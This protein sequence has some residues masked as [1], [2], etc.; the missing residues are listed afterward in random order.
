MLG[1]SAL[2]ALHLVRRPPAAGSAVPLG[3]GAGAAFASTLLSARVLRASAPA[4][5][6]LLPYCIYRVA[7]AAL[8]LARLRGRATA[9][10]R[11]ALR[12]Q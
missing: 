2:K 6:A 4:R 12:A 10:A 5:G 8:V 3:A 11:S 1:A 9:D 7:L